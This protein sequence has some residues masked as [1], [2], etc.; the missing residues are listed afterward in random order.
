[1]LVVDGDPTSDVRVLADWVRIW[2]VLRDGRPVAG[3][4]LETETPVP[5]A[6]VEPGRDAPGRRAWRSWQASRVAHNDGMTRVLALTVSA[7]ALLAAT[8]QSS[9]ASSVAPFHASI[10]PLSGERRAL[11]AERVWHRGCPVGLSDLR[12]LSVVHVGFDGRAHTGQL[13]V[14]RDVAKPL[15]SVFPQLYAL[16]F[17]VRH[18]RLHDFYAGPSAYPTD[19]DVTASFECRQAVPS[20]CTGGTASGHWSN[21]AYGHAIDL[22]PARTPTLAAVR[23]ATRTARKYVDRTRLRQ[24]MVTPAVVRASAS[25]GWGWGGSWSGSTKDYMHFSTN[26]H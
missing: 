16:R 24:G 2:L 26:G 11:L 19:M 12:V 25:I 14:N 13:V 6:A 22:N 18:M 4:A 20:P 10:R 3:T 9:R 5:R 23:P 17:P 1:M 7:L 8:I 21:H 15:V